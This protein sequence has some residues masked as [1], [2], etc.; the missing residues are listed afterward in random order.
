MNLADF[1][2]SIKEVEKLLKRL[3]LLR[4]KGIKSLNDDGVSYAFKNASQGSNYFNVFNIGLENYDYDFLLFDQ[5]FFQFEFNY[6]NDGTYEIRYAFFQNPFEYKTYKEFIQDII[7][8]DDEKNIDEVGELFI[9]E[10]N[11]FLSEQEINSNYTTIRYDSDFFNYKPLVHSVSHIHIGHANN[12]RIPINKI[13]SP[14]MFTLFVVKHVFYYQWKEMV[15]NDIDFVKNALEI[16]LK[17]AVNLSVDHWC[18]NE[19]LELF[20]S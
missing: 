6:I 5:S 17:S 3:E 11:Q 20:L 19:G 2:I 1:K 9:E 13:I 16:G 14:L 4:M 12:I 18:E 15:T 7:F 8:D 10:Y